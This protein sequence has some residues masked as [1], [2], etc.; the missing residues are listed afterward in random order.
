MFIDFNANNFFFK[1]KYQFII[2]FIISIFAF[3]NNLILK[4]NFNFS[5]LKKVNKI[6]EE[7][8][9]LILNNKKIINKIFL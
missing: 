4:Q 9:L 6:K 5:I 2:F 8:I 3:K 7:K 1:F